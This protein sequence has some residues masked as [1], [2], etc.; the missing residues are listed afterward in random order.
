MLKDNESKDG[1]LFRGILGKFLVLYL[2]TA[3]LK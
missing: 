2:C 3:L 1:K